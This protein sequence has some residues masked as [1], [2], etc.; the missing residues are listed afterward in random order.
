MNNTHDEKIEI[1]RGRIE[2]LVIYEIKEAELDLLERGSAA[3]LELNYA[4]G[5]LSASASFLIALLTTEPGSTALFA[6]LL[7]VTLVTGVLGSFFLQ[8]WRRSRRDVTKLAER[9]RAR[10]DP[11]TKPHRL[12]R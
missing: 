9:I 3:S 8:G 4:I 5:L 7:V 10:L 1:Q 12:R 11:G 6:G 2:S